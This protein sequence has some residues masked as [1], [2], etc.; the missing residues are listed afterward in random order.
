MVTT[1]TPNRTAQL[2]KQ[3]AAEEGVVCPR[4]CVLRPSFVLALG[5]GG[6]RVVCV[7]GRSLVGGVGEGV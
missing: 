5:G 1:C 3:G 7:Q 4:G 2:S 6:V